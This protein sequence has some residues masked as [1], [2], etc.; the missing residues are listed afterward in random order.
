MNIPTQAK[1]GLEWATGQFRFMDHGAD[2][3]LNFKWHFDGTQVLAES[4]LQKAGYQY[5][6]VGRDIGYD[7]FRLPAQGRDSTHFLVDQDPNVALPSANGSGH[8]GE[9]YPGID[10]LWHDVLHQ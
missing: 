1:T 8:S 10:H 3:T 7:E 2:Q 9:Y 5:W 6:A 4:I